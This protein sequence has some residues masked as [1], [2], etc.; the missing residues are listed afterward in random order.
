MRDVQHGR[1]ERRSIEERVSDPPEDETPRRIATG[2][3][4]AIVA[5]VLLVLG[6]G[7]L[8]GA[9]NR[10][11]AP[12]IAGAGEGGGVPEIATGPDPIGG[13]TTGG[14][15]G[16][17]PTGAGSDP[18]ADMRRRYLPGP[19]VRIEGMIPAA[20]PLGRTAGPRAWARGRAA[21]NPWMVLGARFEPGPPP[22][23]SSEP[24]PRVVHA[25]GES[26]GTP[27]TILA[28]VPATARVRAGDSAGGFGVTSY[29]VAFDGYSGHYVL[30]ATVQTELGVVSAGGSDGASV[31]FTIGAPIRP[32]RTIATTG[33]AFS[34][35]MRIAAV[36][37]QGRVSPYVPRELSI[38][39]VGTGDVEVALTMSEPTDLD[40][41][42]TDPT[43]TTVYYGHTQGVGGGSLDL[44]ANAACSGNMGVNT[45]HVFYPNGLAPRGSY[46]VR[47]AH[48]ESCV[49][50]RPV[51]YR[52]TVRAC[53][54]TVVL[55]G[56]F[57]GMGQSQQCLSGGQDP[58]WCQDVVSFN[59]P[60]CRP[61]PN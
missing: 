58:S 53:G 51:D 49:Q 23:T 26:V 42:V 10:F 1:R 11:A 36:D 7:L 25:P 60:T 18:V 45:E 15:W 6:G 2:C 22:T 52:V 20:D 27:L 43:G 59:L 35:T 5:M 4:I 47:V 34:V 37:D 21:D 56:R 24:T 16:S 14:G 50:G 30:P 40:L 28:G 55:V 46:T 41:Y 9:W 61:P 54:E 8:V 48:Y 3:T 33:D 57:V 17:S 31:R 38:V 12:A 32:D 19:H 13:A 44:D 29:A 39:P